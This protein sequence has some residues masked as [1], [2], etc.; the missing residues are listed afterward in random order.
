MRNTKEHTK[1]DGEFDPFYNYLFVAELSND[2][3]GNIGFVIGAFPNIRYTNIYAKVNGLF[4]CVTTADIKAVAS[5]Q[6]Y[7]IN[8]SEPVS[9]CLRETLRSTITFRIIELSPEF[10]KRDYMRQRSKKLYS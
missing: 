8:N 2:P 1:S 7:E 3:A 10:R 9:Q 6:S 5:Y 4:D